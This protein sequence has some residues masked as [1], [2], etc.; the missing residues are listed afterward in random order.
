MSRFEFAGICS[1]EVFVTRNMVRSTTAVCAS[2]AVA[3]RTV[4]VVPVVP[5]HSVWLHVEV[6][7]SN[8]GIPLVVENVV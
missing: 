7:R 1:H 5:R 3:L 2:G 8:Q 4:Q 6:E